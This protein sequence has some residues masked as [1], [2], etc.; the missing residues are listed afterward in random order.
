MKFLLSFLLVVVVSVSAQPYH[1]GFVSA[2]MGNNNYEVW[3]SGNVNLLS[4]V[5]PTLSDF[6][7]MN[8]GVSN[9]SMVNWMYKWK[10]EKWEQVPHTSKAM[11]Y[12]TM[13]GAS[14]SMHLFSVKLAVTGQYYTKDKWFGEPKDSYL[15]NTE[16]LIIMGK[17]IPVYVKDIKYPNGKLISGWV[18]GI[19][20]QV[21]VMFARYNL[22]GDWAAGISIPLINYR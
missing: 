7:G 2:G 19:Y 12:G 22:A 10:I 13:Y 1:V 18:Y 9:F 21:G 6:V 20:A 4:K 17:E 11:Y 3:V 5:I 14:M 16:S 15:E 8:M